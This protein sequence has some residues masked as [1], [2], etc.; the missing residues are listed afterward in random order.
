VSIATDEKVRQLELRLTEAENRIARL[1]AQFQK[2][3]TLKIN[4]PG[5][6]SGVLK[7]SRG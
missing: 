7:N 6:P 2:P 3:T 4:G 5:F 1:E